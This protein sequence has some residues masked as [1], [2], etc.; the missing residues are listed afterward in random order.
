MSHTEGKLTTPPSGWNAHSEKGQ[1]VFTCWNSPFAPPVDIANAR[2]LVTCWNEHDDLV[3]ERDELLTALR[4]VGRDCAT[5][6]YR[7]SN[8]TETNVSAI[9]AKYPKETS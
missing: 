6:M 5:T 7:L 1:L 4:A 9:L 2:R 8:E 3:K